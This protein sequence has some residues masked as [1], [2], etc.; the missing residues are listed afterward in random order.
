M[1]LNGCTQR[2]QL[3]ISSVN[4]KEEQLFARIGSFS[5]KHKVPILITILVVS[6]L[7][8]AGILTLKLETS[9]YELWI[10]RDSG[11]RRE[12]AFVDLNFG[13]TRTRASYLLI[14]SNDGDTLMTEEKM[15]RFLNLS[16]AVLQKLSMPL[17]A[18]KFAWK[19][20]C[21]R[22]P[23]PH[24]SLP[25]SKITPLDCFKEGAFDYFL[26]SV[27]PF[28]PNL[29][30][31][32]PSFMGKTSQ[33]LHAIAQ[34]GCADWTGAPTPENFVFGG[35]ERDGSGNIS[36]VTSFQMVFYLTSI[37]TV[38]FSSR[39]QGLLFLTGWGLYRQLAKKLFGVAS[40]TETMKSEAERVLLEFELY[41]IAQM[42]EIIA[43]NDFPFDVEYF[44]KVTAFFSQALVKKNE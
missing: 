25:C 27:P 21:D 4:A 24:L 11:L 42:K 26:P 29:Y 17:D 7:G 37:Q 1:V 35:V 22:M 23:N 34:A 31:A 33:Q 39:S 38:R 30:N 16:T 36:S 9:V 41:Y 12:R 43:A 15:T 5:S 3:L 14:T 28:P 2:C 6:L 10:E 40:P 19:D 8:T 32:K 13:A 20:V 44:A 18:N